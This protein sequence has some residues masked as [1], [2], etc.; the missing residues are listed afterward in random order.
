MFKYYLDELRLQSQSVE[1][2]LVGIHNHRKKH[3]LNKP[4]RLFSLTDTRR[5]AHEPL[6]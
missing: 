2:L 4:K 3:R 1:K 5:R 6:R